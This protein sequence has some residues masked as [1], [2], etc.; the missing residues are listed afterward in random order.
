MEGTE[1]M[2]RKKAQPTAVRLERVIPAPPH[3]VYRAWLDPDL[4]R[5]WLAPGGI[6]VRLAEV[7]ARV[8]GQLS[9]LACRVGSRR[10]RVRVRDRRARTGRTHRLSV[11]IRR[12]R[13]NRGTGIRLGLDHYPACGAG[14]SDEAHADSRTAGRS[15][16]RDAAHRRQRAGWLGTRPGEAR[17]HAWGDGTRC[18]CGAPERLNTGGL[19]DA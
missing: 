14:R 6:T 2:T 1:T 13:E 8:G 9:H 4:L 12:A 3:E 11:G 17:C 18:E 10:R 7:E 19:W 16:C 15:R 5:R